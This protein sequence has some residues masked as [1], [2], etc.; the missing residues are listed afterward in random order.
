METIS[1]KRLKGI[2]SK[3]PTNIPTIKFNSGYVFHFSENVLYFTLFPIE[4]LSF[5]VDFKIFTKMLDTF[6]ADDE[7]S[8]TEE[9][10]MIVVSSGD[11]EMK[12]SNYV[13]DS[14]FLEI[15]GDIRSSKE[16]FVLKDQKVFKESMITAASVA[17]KDSLSGVLDCVHLTTDGQILSSDNV[18]AI[19]IQ[20]EE[21]VPREITVNARAAQTI[22]K[23]RNI[24]KIITSL[25]WVAFYD[26]EN[27]I[28]LC[29][30]MPDFQKFPAKKFIDYFLSCEKQQ[31]KSFEITPE[32][33]DLLRKVSSFCDGKNEFSKTIEL[34][35]KKN[36]VSYSA[37][38]PGGTYKK[39]I[40]CKNKDE[41][42]VTL[43]PGLF[44]SPEYS[45]VRMLE[46]AIYYRNGD[47]EYIMAVGG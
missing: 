5:S 46:N 42:S 15:I 45:E 16:S 17:R 18:R 24:Y 8:F 33:K 13:V 26:K 23:N 22:F 1:L 4:D 44:I 12:I 47:S 34:D 20:T 35:F 40:S 28:Y 31:G 30:L 21:D 29:S 7:I 9:N 39:K 2:L 6:D 38:I 19:K 10:D 3:F 41:F 43:H 14:G 37:T 32:V 11:T 25:D 36:H 27:K